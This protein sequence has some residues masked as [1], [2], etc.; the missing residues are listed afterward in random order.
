[1]IDATNNPPPPPC[2]FCGKLHWK[3]FRD[4]GT[5]ATAVECLGC[6]ARGPLGVPNEAEALSAWADR[7]PVKMIHG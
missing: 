5:W 3:F 6:G 4:P 7:A 2:P 1:M